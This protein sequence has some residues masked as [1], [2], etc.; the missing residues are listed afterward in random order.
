MKLK[1]LDEMHANLC[2]KYSWYC[3]WHENPNHAH[4]HWGIFI[5]VAVFI[6]YSLI[7]ATSSARGSSMNPEIFASEN[8]MRILGEDEFAILTNGGTSASKVDGVMSL[9]N[10]TVIPMKLNDKAVVSF[11]EYDPTKTTYLPKNASGL[12]IHNVADFTGYDQNNIDTAIG[13]KLK[14]QSEVPVIIRMKLH[15]KFYDPRDD[16][17][18]RAS[19]SQA[20]NNAKNSINSSIAGGGSIKNDLKIINGVSANVNENALEALKKNPNV[21][22]V[23]L[24]REVKVFLDES[25]NEI[26]APYAWSLV[27]QGGNLVTGTGMRIAILDTGV[28][29]NQPDLG[30]CLGAT[31]KVIGGYDFINNDAD[32]MDDHGHGTHVAATAAGKGLLNGVAPDAKIIGYKVLSAGGS[33]SF[34]VIIA[35]IN[36]TVDP[37]QDGNPED[38]VDVASMSLGATC[39]AYTSGC[40]PDDAMSLAVDNA[41]NAGV[42]YTIAAGNA[43]PSL[44]TV[45]SPGTARS[46]ITVAAACKA[47]QAG[48][49][50]YCASGPIATFSSRGPVI[51]ANNVDLQKPDISAP[52]VYICAARWGT[53]F[54]GSPICFDDKHIRISGTSM[55]T[56]HMGG[57]AALMKQA[58]PDY[59]PAQIKQ[60]LKDTAK[61][62]SGVSYNAQGAGEVD[63]QT[64]I[65]IISKVQSTPNIWK[66]VTDP[67]KKLSTSTQSFSVKSMDSS[68]TTLTPSFTSPATG[69]TFTPS[70]TTLALANMAT[71]TFTG[72]ITIDNDVVKTGKYTGIIFLMQ[73]TVKKGAITIPIEVSPTLTATPVTADYGMDNPSLSSWTSSVVPITFTN[74]RADIAQ[75]FT[76]SP[77]TYPS[78]VTYQTGT[79]GTVTIPANGTV[80]LNT[81][82][83]A[84]NATLPNGTYSG[85]LRLTNATNITGVATK[86]SKYYSIVFQGSDADMIGAYLTFWTS[87]E[88]YTFVPV[89]TNPFTAYVNSSGS[90][91]AEIDFPNSINRIALKEGIVPNGSPVTISAGDASRMISIKPTGINGTLLPGLSQHDFKYG[92]S[93][94]SHSVHSNAPT[95]FEFYASPTSSNSGLT[96]SGAST[97]SANPFYQFGGAVPMSTGD[98]SF[99][100]TASDLKKVVVN[101]TFNVPAGTIRRSPEVAKCVGLICWLISNGNPVMITTPFTHTIYSAAQVGYYLQHFSYSAW[102][103]SCPFPCPNNY[104][105]PLFDLQA[106]VQKITNNAG[107]FPVSFANPMYSGLGPPAFLA[108]FQ[109]TGSLIKLAPP[110]SPSGAY[111]FRHDLSMPETPAIPY[112][113]SRNGSTLYTGFFPEIKK[114]TLQSYIYQIA[115]FTTGAGVYQLSTSIP[116]QITGQNMNADIVASFNTS[117][118]DPNPPALQRLYF[119]TDNAPSEVYNAG[120]S[121]KLEVQFDPNLGTISTVEA[122]Y[123][124]D[125][126]NYHALTN[127]LANGVYTISVPSLTVSGKLTLSLKAT[128][129]SG[130]YF[131]Y[132]FELPTTADAP[133]LDTI[134][135]TVSITSPIPNANIS[136]TSVISANASDNI[137]VDRVDFYNGTNLIG[138]TSMTPYSFSWDTTK[139]TNGTYSLTAKAY[140]LAGNNATS[141]P[142]S[143]TLN[144]VVTP[145]DTTAPTSSITAPTDSATLTGTTVISATATDNI[146]VDH[147]DFY[148]GTTLIGADPNAPYSISWDT[149]GSANGSYVLT[150]KAYD[151][152]GNF[153]TSAN[154]NVTVSNTVTTPPDTTSPTASITAPTNGA[155]ISGSA[156]LSAT[157]TDN[158]G[159][160]KVSFYRGT[161]LIDTDTTASPSYA[162]TWDTTTVP[163]GTYS[164]TAK[165]YDVAG[166]IGT[167]SAINVTVKNVLT[168]PDTTAPA[169]S[170]VSP[171]T[172]ILPSKGSVKVTAN[173]TDAS[174]IA[175]IAIVID[176]IQVKSCINV[177]TCTYSWNMNQATKGSHTIVAT[178]KDNANPPNIGTSTNTVN[179]ALDVSSESLIPE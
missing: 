152:V 26:N 6:S 53:A 158:V 30:G 46:A 159:V 96:F 66:P 80:T 174:G 67:T 141:L 135:P 83:S 128:D 50:S 90:F 10:G 122:S 125:G 147:V 84:N 86:F 72:T 1:H 69:I 104:I 77:G 74:K 101:P 40:G 167:T 176:S 163:D 157:A 106:G 87:S 13:R 73:G 49:N 136:G 131:Q 138:T 124:T 21:D 111:I 169:V 48:L 130:N 134:A 36:R 88:R 23:D 162:I 44:N 89:T 153:G 110:I 164:L 173:A 140:D 146:G 103:T 19:K 92:G 55:A 148:R 39:G 177:T 11:I 121:N 114:L 117:L 178:A 179:Q 7:G 12:E 172:P 120:K 47:S 8:N 43:G 109:N 20:F 76:V 2:T 149:T 37:N 105:M 18:A 59:T 85:V 115:S 61:N 16:A 62:F 123:A 42:V 15:S 118:G 38:H 150:T 137:G 31:C 119:Y 175:S 22:K 51:D 155:T 68:I 166:N 142:V 145:P 57:V 113:I 9:G 139:I 91:T 54:S 78:G 35:A 81:S 70:K 24:D 64:A 41:S 170:I 129:N 34:S 4:V 25:I 75:T 79:T 127:T 154:I 58:N 28:D 65:P 5:A 98:Y 100:N 151:K 99:T 108:K 133:I 97:S 165:A 27:D 93:P 144:N 126:T 17:S 94:L 132:T 45:G 29:Y 160:T 33:G 32:P 82:I 156:T 116:Y 14:K 95:I 171:T 52:G 71:D 3:R 60:R 143:V 112:Q 107:T 102:D 168:P 63:L 161:T 56:P